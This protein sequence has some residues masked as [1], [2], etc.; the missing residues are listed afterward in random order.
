VYGWR[1]FGQCRR[2]NAQLSPDCH[3]SF[4]FAQ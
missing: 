4:G 3:Y 2:G 1:T